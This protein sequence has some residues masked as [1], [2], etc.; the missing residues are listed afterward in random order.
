MHTILAV[1]PFYRKIRSEPAKQAIFG[2]LGPLKTLHPSLAGLGLSSQA[3]KLT[4]TEVKKQY[5]NLTALHT[6]SVIT[7]LDKWLLKVV[8]KVRSSHTPI[9]STIFVCAEARS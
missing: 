9:V 1:S 6:L 5:P 4:A 8:E 7:G 2:Y 3:L